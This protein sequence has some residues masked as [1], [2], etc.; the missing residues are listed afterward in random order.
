[1]LRIE[2]AFELELVPFF[3][4]FVLLIEALASKSIIILNAIQF[5][6]EPL[7]CDLDN[8]KRTFYNHKTIYL[9]T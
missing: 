1:M 3:F 2:I 4:S 7:I 5:F 8:N 6:L 9:T